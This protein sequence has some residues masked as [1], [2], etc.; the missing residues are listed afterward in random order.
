MRSP[1][2]ACPRLV[3]RFCAAVAVG[4]LAVTAVHVRA[5]GSG[6]TLVDKWGPLPAGQ[7]W[8]EVT[9]VVVDAKNTI[10]AVRRTDPPII[11][12]DPSGKVRC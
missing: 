7:E 10:I 1:M 4:A 5:D 12:M 3:V 8:G 2:P 11:E 6:Y 9:G